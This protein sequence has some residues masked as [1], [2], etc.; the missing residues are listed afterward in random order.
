MYHNFFI[1]SSVDG[2]LGCILGAICSPHTA[3]EDKLF[4]RVE[5]EVWRAEVNK[6]VSFHWPS[7]CQERRVFFL[8]DLS[9]ESS[10]FWPSRSINWGFFLLF[11]YISPPLIK[12]SLSEYHWS[13]V[14]FSSF[15]GFFP[16]NFRNYLSW[17]WYLASERNSTEWEIT[18]FIFE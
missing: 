3:M 17:V 5:K 14:R 10:S 11:F 6:H 18:E 12:I 2:H 13:R 9:H 7:H 1:H 4:Y 15:N 16:L 8:L